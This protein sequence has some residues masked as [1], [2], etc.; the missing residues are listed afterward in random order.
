[1]SNTLSKIWENI[2]GCDEH[3]R[4]ASILYLMSMLSQTS[5]VIIDRSIS[6]PGH[7]IEIADVLKAIDKRFLFQF[8]STVQLPGAKSHDT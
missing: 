8:M 4:S 1:M 6:A 3:Y 7:G 5:Y 2:Y